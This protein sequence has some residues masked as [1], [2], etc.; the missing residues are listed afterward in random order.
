M[1]VCIYTHTHTWQFVNPLE[2]SIFS[3]SHQVHEKTK[4]IPEDLRKIV[5]DAHQA[6]KG[7]KTISKEFGLH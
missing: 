4:E 3:I 1:Y 5:V 7:Y 2:F 6:R